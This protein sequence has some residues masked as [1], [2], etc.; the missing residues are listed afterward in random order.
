MTLQYPERKL[1]FINVGL[2]SETV[3]YSL[4][5]YFISKALK[6]GMPVQVVAENCGTSIRM[7][8]AHYGKFMKSDRRAMLNEVELG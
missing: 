1:E 3:F 7:I 6:S 2:P 8:E 5:H 4:R